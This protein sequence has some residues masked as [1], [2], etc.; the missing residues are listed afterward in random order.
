MSRRLKFTL[1][2]IVSLVGLAGFGTLWLSLRFHVPF[3]PKSETRIVEFARGTSLRG[4]SAKLEA[5]GFIQSRHLFTLL[6]WVRNRSRGLQAGEYR[7]SASMS[8]AEILDVL[9]RGAVVQHAL[10][11]PEG[12]NIREIAMAVER[13][14]V[15]PAKAIMAVSTD[16]AFLRR[17]GIRAK[18]AEGY[19]FPETYHFP[20][21]SP[22]GKILGRM[23]GTFRER[24]TA[25]MVRRAEA[26]HLAIHQVVTLASIIERESAVN[27]E[28]PLISAVFH[29]RLRRRMRLQADPTVLYALNRTAGPLTKEDLKVAS[30]Y[31][32]YRI[33]GLPPG[34]IANPGLASLRAALNPAPV[35]Y[36]YFV[37][38]GDGGHDFS[39]TL[40]DHVAAV[41]RYR[42]NTA[43][44][45][46][47][48]GKKR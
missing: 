42:K 16:P 35:D 15:S 25:A 10:T 9:A 43:G 32:T 33:K 40:K 23:A 46:R 26:L 20:R 1:W 22:P 18:N 48:S 36:L 11:I 8:P 21:N 29:N 4:I 38:R 47:A 7:L 30:P 24:F 39:R 14:G 31:N 28:K 2:G 27:A 45:P 12:Y 34:P 19:L 3:R 37:A 13:A 17:F 44:S 5:K 41:R 6:A